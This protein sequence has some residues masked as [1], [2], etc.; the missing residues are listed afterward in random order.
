LFE[1]RPWQHFSKFEELKGMPQIEID[2]C[3]MLYECAKELKSV[4]SRPGNMARSCGDIFPIASSTAMTF[5]VLFSFGKAILGRL[6]ALS[7]AQHHLLHIQQASC[8]QS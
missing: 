5:P 8:S 4:G 6:L 7:S 2:E 3:E 1:R